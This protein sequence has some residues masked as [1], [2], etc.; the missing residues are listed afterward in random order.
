MVLLNIKNTTTDKND[1]LALI[2]TYL[3]NSTSSSIT[4]NPIIIRV[5][6]LNFDIIVLTIITIFG[7]IG[8]G[9]IFLLGLIKRSIRNMKNIFLLHHCIINLMQSLLCLPFVISLLTNSANLEGCEILGGAYVTLV[10]ASIISIA[11][12]IIAEAYY[13]EDVVIRKGETKRQNLFSKNNSTSGKSNRTASSFQCVMF[14]ILMIWLTSIILHLGIT[15]IGS[16]PKSLYN[17]EIRNCFFIIGDRRTYVLYIMWVIVTTLSVSFIIRYVIKI[18][19]SV[20]KHKYLVENFY[21]RRIPI[22]P[23]NRD[24]DFLNFLLKTRMNSSNTNLDKND[25]KKKS[26]NNIKTCSLPSSYSTNNQLSLLTDQKAVLKFK[27]SKSLKDLRNCSNDAEFNKEKLLKIKHNR[28]YDMI[29]QALQKI[30]IQIILVI[31][32]TLCWMPLFLTV[33]F[34]SLVPIAP[35][36]YKY[37]TMI[38]CTNSSITPYCYLTILIP[39]LNKF[40]LPCLRSDGKQNA[41]KSRLHNVLTTYYDKIGDRFNNFNLSTTSLNSMTKD[42]SK[43][44]NDCIYDKI[45]YGTSK[46]VK[47]NNTITITHIDERV[48]RKLNK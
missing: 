28:N 25:F 40:C 27:R 37:L 17:H 19:R 16:D 21:L 7:V 33:I 38:A 4:T 36:V 26:L 11:A 22:T 23:R 35:K 8:N 2:L 10:T 13:F 44:N 18:Y 6:A 15:M 34:G 3:Q 24:A 29:K 45:K 14:G 39:K 47:I 48:T 30:K 41:H 31:F 20:L 32:F 42:F 46:S 12:M 5:H 9:T 43:S 1:L